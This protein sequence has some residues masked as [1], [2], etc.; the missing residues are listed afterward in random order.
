MTL[1]AASSPDFRK[2]RLVH[3]LSAALVFVLLG[4][5][6]GGGG[7]NGGGGGG[8]QVCGS[9]QG[10]A[11]TV[12]CGHVTRA[13]DRAGVTGAVVTLKNAS[14][15]TLASTTSAGSDGFFRFDNVPSGAALF[16][17]DPPATEYYE[18]AASYKGSIYVYTLN[19]RSNDGPC[20]PS[21]GTLAAGDN[22]IGEIA[23]F[24]A[25]QPPYSPPA[26][27]PR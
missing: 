11:R 2:Q 13:H 24:H 8:V 15:Q 10:D 5:G 7:D 18:K 3:A 22:D 16:Q 12:V 21:L 17:V 14:G 6:G 4:C 9:P 19:N 27:C 1:G 23:V 25:S 26:G 20:I